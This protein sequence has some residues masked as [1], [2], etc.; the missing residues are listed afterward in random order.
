MTRRPSERLFSQPGL[1][2]IRAS[3]VHRHVE[4][5]TGAPPWSRPLSA[6][7]AVNVE[8]FMPWSITVTQ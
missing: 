5:R 1:G 7:T 2:M 8:A 4:H 6:P 3:D